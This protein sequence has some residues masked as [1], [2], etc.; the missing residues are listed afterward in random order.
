MAMR[1]REV[2][3]EGRAFRCEWHVKIE[4][5]RNRIHFT[6]PGQGPGGKILIGLFVKHLS[7]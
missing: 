1:E 2:T 5:H 6:L 7:T 3:Y 4:R